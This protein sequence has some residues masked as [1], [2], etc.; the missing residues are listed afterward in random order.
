MLL[1]SLEQ[2]FSACISRQSLCLMEMSSLRTDC[3]VNSCPRFWSRKQTEPCM[4]IT[5]CYRLLLANSTSWYG[6]IRKESKITFQ[7]RLLSLWCL[8]G[9]E[10]QVSAS[11][12]SVLIGMFHLRV[13]GFKT[14]ASAKEEPSCIKSGW[15]SAFG[16]IGATSIRF[17]LPTATTENQIWNMLRR[18]R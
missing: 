3:S 5:S 2:W 16:Q 9:T 13:F 7:S 12:R 15:T 14:S 18:Q 1:W 11:F 10:F 8:G 6:G 4:E 17:S